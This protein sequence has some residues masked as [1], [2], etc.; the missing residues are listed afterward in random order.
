MQRQGGFGPV[1]LSPEKP[2]SGIGEDSA[3]RVDWEATVEECVLDS[4]DYGPHDPHGGD[5]KLLPTARGD[6]IVPA[7]PTAP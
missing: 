2:P 1:V 5:G 4:Q 7:L 3:K 6:E